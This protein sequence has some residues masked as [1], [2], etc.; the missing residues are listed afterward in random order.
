MSGYQLASKNVKKGEDCYNSKLT[1]LEGNTLMTDIFTKYDLADV[2]EEIEVPPRPQGSVLLVGSSGSGKTTILKQWGMKDTISLQESVPIIEQ[3]SSPEEGE[4]WLIAAGLRTVPA[5]R[6]PPNELSNGELHR[7]HIALIASQG[8]TFFDE[9]TSLVDR[10]TA[11]ALCISI[12]RLKT[13]NYTF[14]SCHTDI[15]AWLSVDHI[16]DTD[17]ATWLDRGAL[18]RCSEFTF[19]IRPCD[20]QKVWKLFKKHHYLSR[21]VNKAASAWCAFYENKPIAFCSI[22]AFPNRNFS[23]AYRGHRTVVLP[24]FQGM[25]I[26]TAFSDAIAHHVVAQ[27]YRFFS[28]TAHPAMGGHREGAAAWRP[29]SKNKRR[30][31]DYNQKRA[32]K[33]SK[34]KMA[35]RLRECYSHE[36]ILEET[37]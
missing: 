4:Q 31:E 5:W 29:T 36:Y 7:A 14:A 9:F 26:G 33:E 17:A 32:S 10:H 24:E 25:G 16:Y 11:R 12:N 37:H 3:F 21:K 8:G 28:K 23:N 20:A 30:R 35:H 15:T 34:H 2:D 27:G 6:R 1:T 19:E 18:R 22:L 13:A